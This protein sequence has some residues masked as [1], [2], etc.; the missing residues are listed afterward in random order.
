VVL[1][2]ENIPI[3]VVPDIADIN[4]AVLKESLAKLSKYKVD[5]P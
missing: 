2:L 1:P 5:P 3:A 4:A